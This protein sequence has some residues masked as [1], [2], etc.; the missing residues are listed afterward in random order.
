GGN[1]EGALLVLSA[2][3]FEKCAAGAIAVGERRSLLA[4]L[5]AN[6]HSLESTRKD[7]LLDRSAREVA[8]SQVLARGCNLDFFGADD[9]NHFMFARALEGSGCAGVHCCLA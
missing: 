4:V 3:D 2:R 6:A 7:N 8:G 1:L 9:G 5:D